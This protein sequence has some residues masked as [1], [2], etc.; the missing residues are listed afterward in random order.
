M[1]RVAKLH[2][3]AMDHA[4]AQ[5]V[6]QQAGDDASALDHAHRAFELER[7]AALIVV[8]KRSP[9]RALEPTRSVLLRSAA[10]LALDCDEHAEGL[11]LVALALAGE[12]PAEIEAELFEVRGRL[13]GARS[14]T[15]SP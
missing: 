4:S 8:G 7:E 1:S 14:R 13:Q 2:T 6:A 12:P 15:L 3:E 11:R 9:V 10:T 5:M